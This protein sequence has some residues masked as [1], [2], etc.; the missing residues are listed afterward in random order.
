MKENEKIDKYSDFMRKLNTTEEHENGGDTNCK[1]S[2]CNGPQRPG[3]ETGWIDG[4]RE[5]RIHLHHNTVKI[6]LNIWKNPG[7]LRC[8]IFGKSEI[9][10]YCCH[11]YYYSNVATEL[12]TNGIHRRLRVYNYKKKINYLMCV[13]VI[14]IFT[15]NEKELESFIRTI[16]I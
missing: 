11:Y 15:K 7:D 2:T 12:Y 3:K 14:K 1:W 8:K 16:Q 9:I 4:Q 13:N 6:N 10:T 5:N